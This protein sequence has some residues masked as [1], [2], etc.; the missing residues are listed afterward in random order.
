MNIATSIL[1]EPRANG[2]PEKAPKIT[3]ECLSTNWNIMQDNKK[4]SD[5]FTTLYND[6]A[7]KE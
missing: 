5:C 3:D 7:P 2:D 4:L 6:V 1:P